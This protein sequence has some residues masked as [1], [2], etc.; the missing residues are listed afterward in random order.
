MLTNPSLSPVARALAQK[1]TAL[2]DHENVDLAVL[3]TE[4]GLVINAGKAA[5]HKLAAAAGFTLAL[6]RQVSVLLGL[7]ESR[8]ITMEMADGRFLVCVPFSAGFSRLVLAVIFHEKRSYRRLLRQTA[9]AL[10][11]TLEDF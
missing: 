2:N 9:A 6:S 5:T 8:E 10:Q 1:M 4:D 3:A 11:Q 7:T